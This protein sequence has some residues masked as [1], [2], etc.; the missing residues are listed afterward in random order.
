LSE[1]IGIFVPDEEE[2]KA[3]AGALFD[4]YKKEIKVVSGDSYFCTTGDVSYV[5]SGVG[6]LSTLKSVLTLPR[7][8]IRVM[9]GSAGSCKKDLGKTFLIEETVQDADLTALG[10]KPG[11]IGDSP[12][13]LKPSVQKL[14]Q[15][16]LK[17]IERASSITTNKFVPLDEDKIC[18]IQNKYDLKGPVLVDMEDYAFF[19]GNR[20]LQIPCFVLRYSTDTGD[21]QDWVY[22]LQPAMTELMNSARKLL[23]EVK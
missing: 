16:S 11:E 10:R 21:P 1:K 14:K 15:M 18:R 6:Q 17:G 7:H 3:L 2:A 13:T 5:C 9:I 12:R 20:M 23:K 22:N 4:M 8:S 19:Y